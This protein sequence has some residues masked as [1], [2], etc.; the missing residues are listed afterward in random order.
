MYVMVFDVALIIAPLFMVN[1]D[2][3]IKKC[4]EP[5]DLIP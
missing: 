4:K 1:Q 2:L 5:S 3:S